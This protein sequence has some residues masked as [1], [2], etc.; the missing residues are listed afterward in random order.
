[1]NRTELLR[2]LRA[3]Q[4]ADEREGEMLRRIEDF[5]REYERCFDRELSIGHLTGSAWIV[6]KDRSYALL[7]HHAKLNIWVQLGGH[8]ENDSDMLTAAWREAR[9][10]SGLN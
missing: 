7:T 3:H 1:M 6:D 9:E 10:E 8:V 2:K 4:P 5:V